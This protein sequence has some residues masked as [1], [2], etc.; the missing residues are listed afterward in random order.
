MAN[1]GGFRMAGI[2]KERIR[3]WMSRRFPPRA[4]FVSVFE[5]A[6]VTQLLGKDE[7]TH[8]LVAREGILFGSRDQATPAPRKELVILT[9]VLANYSVERIISTIEKDVAPTL[10]SQPSVRVLIGDDLR[11]FSWGQSSTGAGEAETDPCDAPQPI[12]EVA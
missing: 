7:A 11:V 6:D 3:D 2:A 9:S 4:K 1:N 8:G 5:C 10:D 12:K